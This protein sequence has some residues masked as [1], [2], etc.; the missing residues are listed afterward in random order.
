MQ[1]QT[2]R[3]FFLG[4]REQERA[5]S[6]ALQTRRNIKVIENAAPNGSKPAHLTIARNRKRYGTLPKDNVLDPLQ[7]LQLR[8]KQREVWHRC[9][10]RRREDCGDE[11]CVRCGCARSEERRVGKEC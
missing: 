2:A 8:I 11:L 4:R 10:P 3:A 7:N 6:L 5:Q 1:A 9:A